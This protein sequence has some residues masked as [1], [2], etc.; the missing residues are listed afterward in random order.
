MRVPER[1]RQTVGEVLKRTVAAHG[2]KPFL[3][4]EERT[5]TFEDIDRESDRLAN[6]LR[7]QGVGRQDTVLIMLPDR[8][9][10]ISVWIAVSKLAAIEVPVNRDY[11]GALLNRVIDHSEAAVMVVDEAYLDRIAASADQLAHLKR[12]IVYPALNSESVPEA[13]KGRFALVSFEELSAH[14]DTAIEDEAHC[15]DLVA[16]LYTS[17]T[18]GPSKGVM[19][20]HAHAYEYSNCMAEALDLSTEDVYFAPLPLFH[21]AGQWAVVYAALITN[22][23]VVLKERFSASRFWDVVAEHGATTSLLLDVMANFLLSQPERETDSRTPL[24]KIH[25]SPVIPEVRDFMRRFDVAV[26]TDLASTEMCAPL[27]VGYE[28]GKTGFFHI[29]D[30]GSLGREVSDRFEVRLVD[31]NEEEVP[32]GQAGELCVRAKDP[33][34]LMAG[35]WKDPEAT[36]K[37]W[38]NLWLHTGDALRCDEDGNFY[39]V[40]RLKDAIR[41]RGENISS[42]EVENEVNTHPAVLESAAFGAKAEIGDDEVMVVVALKSGAVLS[43]EELIEYLEPRMARFMIPRFVEFVE[44]LPKT[45]N[46]KI[47]KYPLRERGVTANTWDRGA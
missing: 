21:I 25:L 29:D 11:R 1:N 12:L 42:M 17:G 5:V 7:A 40:D 44:E 22:A 34:I 26:T 33:W 37:A 30:S 27:R 2:D 8:I 6:G 31:D 24:K 47:R 28:P 32:P 14:G 43:P 39:Y 46:G 4:A 41:R 19:I 36:V 18:T 16:V 45:E 15:N 35:Y 10:L 38:R 20:Y 3:I 13:L 23:T 9:D